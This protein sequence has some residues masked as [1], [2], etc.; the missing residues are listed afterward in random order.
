MSKILIFVVSFKKKP[1]L[2]AYIETGL[3]LNF[4]IKPRKKTLKNVAAT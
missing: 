4:K 2:R 3:C 1:G